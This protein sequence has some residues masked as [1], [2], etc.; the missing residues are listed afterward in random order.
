MAKTAGPIKAH[1]QAMRRGLV[2]CA[3]VIM[4]MWVTSQ[5]IHEFD[6]SNLLRSSSELNGRAAAESLVIRRSWPRPLS[7]V[8]PCD[9]RIH[10]GGS[11]VKRNVLYL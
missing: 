1:R 10:C 2:G 3:S 7:F 8:Q 5:G 4:G 6:S 11:N 9:V